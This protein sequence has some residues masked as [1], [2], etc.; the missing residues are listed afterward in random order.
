MESRPRA[1]PS[2]TTHLNVIDPTAYGALTQTLLSVFGSK[3]VLP[4]RRPDEQRRDVVR[5]ASGGELA[6]ARETAAH[7]HVPGVARRGGKPWFAIGASGGRKIFSRGAADRPRFRNHGMSLED[8]FHHPRIDAS[9]G[10]RVA[11]FPS[12]A[13]VQ[14]ALGE[15]FPTHSTE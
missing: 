2:S 11:R 9:G 5:S 10:E 3:V 4:A 1:G 14:E 13:E 8:A 15:K 6:G 12:A 7:Q